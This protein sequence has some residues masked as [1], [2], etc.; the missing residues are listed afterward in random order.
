MRPSVA[1]LALVLIAA[2]CSADE[3]ADEVGDTV[4]TTEGEAAGGCAH[5]VAA[6][7]ERTGDNFTVSATVG[8][9]DMGWEKYADAFEVRAP[10]GTVL[11]TRILAHPHVDEQP[12]TRSLTGVEIPAGTTEVT[13]AARD[14]VVGFCGEVVVLSVP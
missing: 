9:A 6:T 3:G 4:T 2:A 8:S 7:I 10:D 12:F 1:V 14:L 11:G 13:V 5:V